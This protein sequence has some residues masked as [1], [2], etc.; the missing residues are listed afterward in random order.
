[1]KV[2]FHILKICQVVHFNFFSLVYKK[3]LVDIM[4]KKLHSIPSYAIL[5]VCAMHMFMLTPTFVYEI[6]IEHTPL[7]TTLIEH[8]LIS[9]HNSISSYTVCLCYVVLHSTSNLIH[10]LLLVPVTI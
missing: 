10:I 6:L 2:G 8:T 1:M 7:T 3:K 4:G 5:H 9:R